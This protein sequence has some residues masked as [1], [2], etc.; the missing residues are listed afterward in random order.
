[1]KILAVIVLYKS[2]LEVSASYTSLLKGGDDLDYFIYDN[3]PQPMHKKTDFKDYVYVHDTYNSGISMA[4]NTAA[5]HARDN[6]YDW[7]LLLDQDTEFPVDTIL[8]YKD[9]INRHSD[10]MLFAPVLQLSDKSFFSPILEKHPRRNGLYLK[11]GIYNI[12][13]YKLVNS[14]LLINVDAFWTSGGYNENVRL[15]FADFQFVKR[16]RKYYD[17]FFII[18]CIATQDFSSHDT[19][20]DKLLTRFVLYCQGAKMFETDTLQEKMN[21]TYIVFRRMCGLILKTKRINFFNIYFKHY[22]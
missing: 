17:R 16:Y 6:G 3:S 5:A 11:S 12:C 21:L 7:L 8:K 4:Y 19:D 15:D 9:A 2:R 10:I 1:M 14:G 18:D 13:D 22:L 20:V